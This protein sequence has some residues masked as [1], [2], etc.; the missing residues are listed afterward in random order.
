MFFWYTKQIIVTT[1]AYVKHENHKNLLKHMKENRHKTFQRSERRGWVR[2]LR[3]ILTYC[4]NKKRMHV[5]MQIIL[6][7]SLYNFHK[8]NKLRKNNWVAFNHRIQLLNQFLARG[9]VAK[10]WQTEP[11]LHLFSLKHIGV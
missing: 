6:S 11:P 5:N 1:L 3:G 9:D 8:E 2:K 4:E 10:S 7:L